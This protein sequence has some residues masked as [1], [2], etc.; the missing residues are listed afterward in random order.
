M[1]SL[2]RL[3][4][5]PLSAAIVFTLLPFILMEYVMDG[6]YLLA[7]VPTLNILCDDKRTAFKFI[8]SNH[9]TVA[10][11]KAEFPNSIAVRS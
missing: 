3:V 5:V 2:Q 8:T 7:S 6:L 4:Q 11:L 1:G 9:A 10:L